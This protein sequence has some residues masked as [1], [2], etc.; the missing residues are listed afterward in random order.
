MPK[1][2]T[3]EPSPVR[4]SERLDVDRLAEYLGDH[5]ADFDGPL[6]VRQ[7]RKGHSNLTYLIRDGRREWVLRRPP[8]GS[9]VA[10][11]HD[12]GREYRVL[13][14]L[15]RAYEPAP[16]ALLYCD[17]ESVIGAPFYVMERV[18]GV[19][20]RRDPPAG[21]VVDED[22]AERLCRALVDNL[23]RIHEVD[24][25]K[26]GL[27]DLGSPEGYIERQVSGWTRRYRGSQTDD[28]PEMEAL[29]EWLADKMPDAHN[30]ALIHND[31]KFDN[32][33]LDPT[34]LTHIV[35]VLD[36]EMCTVGH[37]LMDLGTSLSYWVQADDPPP[38]VQ[39][40]FGP[41]HL[42]GMY[43]RQQVVE[44]YAAVSGRDVSA[45]D[46]YRAFGLFKT[47][48]VAQQIYYRFATGKTDDKRFA[49]M[50]VGVRL[51]SR[52]GAGIIET[53]AL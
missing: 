49:I 44:R 12:M 51:L 3:D 46:F 16:R 40:R 18:R 39:F 50:I 15:Y 30:G 38:I 7:F 1:S 36:W 33:V 42:P 10:T 22:L 45:I 9:K 8:F 23:V 47:A 43:T 2:P 27:C 31:Y 14:G 20:V 6:E 19:I 29:T 52:T 5:L 11:A 37:P 35:G 24:L 48:V 25:A 21:V 13:K 34:D 53:S 17:D 28:I 26:A 4:D 41:T 32:V